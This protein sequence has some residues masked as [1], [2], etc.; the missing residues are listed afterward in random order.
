VGNRRGVCSRT[1]FIEAVSRS[2]GSAVRVR[3]SLAAFSLLAL[4]TLAV[5]GAQAQT[6]STIAGGG[7]P[8][9]VS[10]TT[11]PIGTPWGMVQDGLGNTYISDHFSSRIF[12]VDSTGK[13]SVVAGDGINNYNGDTHAAILAELSSPQGLA[14]DATTNIG[15]LYIADTGNDVI[16]VVNTGASAI[17]LFAHT[18]SALTVGPGDIDT[19]P[20]GTALSAPAGVAVDAA[21][22]IYIAD[23]GNSAIR[24]LTQS[25]GAMTVVAGNLTAGY[26]GDG[27]AA[28]SAELNL[29]AGITLDASGDVFIA[30]TANHAIRVV[31]LSGSTKSFFGVSIA[32][33]NIDTIAGTPPTAC[34]TPPSCGDGVS[35]GAKSAAFNAPDGV[36]LD[37]S[38]NLW[39]ADT[40]DQ[41][42]RWVDSTA[43]VFLA[44][45][46]YVTTCNVAPCG[47]GGAPT[48]ANFSVPTSLFVDGSGNLLVADEQDN[49]VRKITTP[50]GSGTISTTF[51]VIFNQGYYGDGGPATPNAELLD[52][53]GVAVDAAGNVYIADTDNNVIRKVDTHG[54]I[55]TVAG[56][57]SPCNP[58]GNPGC[59]D[60][61]AA[62]AAQLNGPQGVFVDGSGNIFIADTRDNAIREVVA[63]TG[64]IQAVA[65]TEALF[66]CDPTSTPGC[67]DGGAAGSAS[68]GFPAAVFLDSAGNIYI[69]DTNS[70]VI[71]AVNL[72]GAA[73]IANVSIAK[74]DIKTIAGT[75]TPCSASPCGDGGSAITALLNGP[76]ALF[77][78]SA[79]NVF[80]SDNGDNVIRKVNTA[81]TISNLAGDY[82][83]CTVAPC[84]DGG[85]A[86][87]AQFKNVIGVWVDA[88]GNVFAADAGRSCIRAIN[89][90]SSTVT[91][92]GT[93]IDPGNIDRVVATAVPGYLDGPVASA[94]LDRPHGLAADKSGN[95]FITDTATQRVRKVTDM[96]ASLGLSASSLTFQAPGLGT[97][98]QQTVTVTNNGNVTALAPTVTVSGTDRAD[99]TEGN[100]CASLAAGVAC[101]ITVTF[102]PSAS[103]TRTATMTIT[104]NVANS[105]QTVALS[106]SVAV[107]S[108]TLPKTGTLSPSSVSAGT[109]AKGTVTVTSVNNFSAAVNLTCAVT[110]AGTDAPTCQFDKNP[111][112]PQGGSTAS[113][114][115]T[116][117]TTPPNTALAPAIKHQSIFYATWLFVPA[118]LLS[119]VG[120]SGSQR[121]K[122]ISTVL[123]ILAIA[124]CIFLVACGGGSSS[125]NNGGG[126]TGG[127]PAGT[128]T[129]T[130][131]ATSTGVTPPAPEVFTLTVTQ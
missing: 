127:T 42:V 49:S 50:T 98:T 118:M 85:T 114:T 4:F 91:I 20:A 51:G 25:S 13:L 56:T 11:A 73:K 103:G 55:T 70:N 110:P 54:T 26:S 71:R 94:Q 8:N 126:S 43:T 116:V 119:T 18:G 131:T 52:S 79:G 66:P 59:G 93:P 40:G 121:R 107:A 92:A 2:S 89:T 106:G 104:D 87:S 82:T 77:V 97:S 122:M 84:G 60:G 115:L 15:A 129:I 128:Y 53:Q 120:M 17:T 102:T 1:K 45:G 78:D 90:S 68:L 61:A 7:P 38:G 62:T 47:D 74:G 69:A 3:E 123:L 36:F 23:T 125:S 72:S 24:K 35:G 81:G 65:G 88:G 32:N 9:G 28:T 124:G 30:D 16:R 46:T 34:A 108:F 113:A 29:P 58:G 95:L 112:Q 5:L 27:G 111:I 37:G 63:S 130:V 22:N 67:G 14:F 64:K 33:G 101:T 86:T 48:S 109:S 39:I 12:K 99:F 19:V 57:G 75:Y 41:V 76:E 96:L 44:A 21:G 80:I 31:N 100:N 10:A 6:I 83:S 105:P 117:A